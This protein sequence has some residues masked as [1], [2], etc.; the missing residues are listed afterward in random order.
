MAAGG[1]LVTSP[2]WL[3]FAEQY[4]AQYDKSKCFAQQRDTLIA[5][6]SVV[7]YMF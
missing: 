7:P 4:M 2:P 6:I 1:R 5:D 3:T